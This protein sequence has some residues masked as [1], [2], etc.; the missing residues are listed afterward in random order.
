MKFRSLSVVAWLVLVAS[1]DALAHHPI[2][3]KF[4]DADPVH[5]AGIVSFV[6]WRNPHAHVFINVTE[7]GQTLNWAVELESPI[8]LEASGWS[9]DTLEPGD[10]VSVDGIRARDGSRQVWGAA[11]ERD[12]SGARLFGLLPESRNSMQASRPTPRWAD[13]RPAL[14]A[15]P[16]SAGGYWAHP[17]KTVLVEDGVEV[18]INEHGLLAD[19]DD[20]ALVAP[21]Q[22]WALALYRHRQQR[23]LRDDPMYLRCKPPGGVRQ[24]QSRFGFQLIEDRAS[25]RVFVLLGSG[26]RNYRIIY[27][28]GREPLGLV[29]GDD[30]NPLYYGRSTGTW[31]GETLVVETRGFNEDFW[32]TE[33]GLPH[34]DQ[35]HLTERFTRTSLD[36]LEYEVTIDDPGAYTRP[37]SASWNFGWVGGADLPSHFCQH[38]RS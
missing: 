29:S 16:D 25:E 28:D 27:L 1:S 12:G 23:H 4:D 6:D 26:N 15:T 2:L 14:G 13:G 38:N 37:W 19:L 22:P 30:D 7:S 21:F 34:T 11:V 17:S 31:D 35:L 8:T 24:F 3:A 5:L 36:T 33:G 9:R 20:A 32:F 18:G 10:R